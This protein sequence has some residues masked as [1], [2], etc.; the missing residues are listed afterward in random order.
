MRLEDLKAKLDYEL[1]T[2]ANNGDVMGI[3]QKRRGVMQ[4]L[5]WCYE[6]GLLDVEGPNN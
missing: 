1:V 6:N 3:D 4:T 2:C 5:D